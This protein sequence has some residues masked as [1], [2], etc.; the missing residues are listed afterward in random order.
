MAGAA[1]A[2][3]LGA[4]ATGPVT[5]PDPRTMVF[6]PPAFSPPRPERHVLDNGMVVYLLEDHEIPLVQGQA[7][8]RVSALLEPPGKTGLAGLC[9]RM[10][11]QG[12]TE[13]LPGEL[14][15]EV[16]EEKAIGMSS[17]ITNQSGIVSFNALSEDFDTALGLFADVLRRPAFDPGKLDVAK[18][19]MAEEIL[20]VADNPD[21]LTFREFRRLF[22]TDHPRGRSP[23]VEEIRSL[24][25]GEVL[26][27]YGR[28]FHPD[29]IILG[30]SG[31]LET[32]PLLERLEELFGDW[33]PLGGPPPEFPVP[34]I[35]ANDVNINLIDKD[36]PQA[37]IAVGQFAPPKDSPDYAPFMLASYILGEGGFHARLTREIRSNRGLAYSAGSFFRGDIGYGVFVAY[38]KTKNES[39]VEVLRLIGEIT[40]EMKRDGVLGEELAWA[41]ESIINSMIFRYSSSAAVLDE[42]LALD[43][44]GLPPDY[45]TRLK[46]RIEKTTAE[47]VKAAA[48]KYLNAGRE[49]IVILGK[50]SEYRGEWPRERRIKRL[51]L[52]PEGEIL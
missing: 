24:S 30:F 17:G 23:K 36:L 5:G 37:S 14:L 41:T 12:G 32:G 48:E 2:V 18:Q 39:A 10:L 3:L 44:D 49:T 9:G 50:E 29:R 4:C 16:L 26:D 47:E 28:Y 34:D 27:F 35:G 1:A 43:Y 25:G 42:S 6:A 52:S 15:Y 8:I 19:N 11:V 22:Y 21:S 40:E 33:E 31:D 20:R 45:I 38:V 46:E 7:V 51:L 13:K